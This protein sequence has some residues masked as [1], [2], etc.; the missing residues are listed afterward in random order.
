MMNDY[1]YSINMYNMYKYVHGI[2]IE[3]YNRKKKT[4]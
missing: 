3:N 4:I 1:V 2:N